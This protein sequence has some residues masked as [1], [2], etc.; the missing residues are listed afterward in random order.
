MGLILTASGKTCASML[1]KYKQQIVLALAG[2]KIPA[3]KRRQQ[4]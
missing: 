3:G 2:V 1:Q 4:L